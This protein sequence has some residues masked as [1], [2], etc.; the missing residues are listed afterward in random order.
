MPLAGPGQHIH[1]EL[2]GVVAVAPSKQLPAQG[3]VHYPI[4]I[5]WVVGIQVP[6]MPIQK[7]PG[8]GIAASVAMTEM[9]KDSSVAMPK[10]GLC[11]RHNGQ[12][13]PGA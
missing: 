8:E 11:R 5:S 13:T 10:G 9:P 2:F 6:A 1:F 12:W 7:E 3:S 4:E